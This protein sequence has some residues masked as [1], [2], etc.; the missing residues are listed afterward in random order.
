MALNEAHVLGIR[1]GQP[2][3]WCDLL[4]HVLAL[5]EAGPP[6]PDARRILRLTSPAQVRVLLRREH[7][8]PDGYGPA[9]TL[10][11]L[12]AVEDFFASLSWSGSMSGWRFLDDPS[13]ARDWPDRPSLAIDVRPVAGSHSMY[14]FSE[15]GRDEDGTSASYC[16]E[17]TVT[18][19]DL[20]VLHADATLQSLDE[21]TADGRRFWEALY[22]RDERVSVPVQQAAQDRMPS[23]RPY[24]RTNT[25][26]VSGS[27]AP[28]TG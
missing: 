15:C 28:G 27:S 13:L 1:L 22:G 6:G 17:G 9:I 16:V 10:A 25:V 23:W 12:D 21:F 24:A 26:T 20:E 5:P 2:G 19:E 3:A 18:F 8:G 7:P 11:G 14:W 4:L